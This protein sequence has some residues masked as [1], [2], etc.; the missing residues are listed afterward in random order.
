MDLAYEVA[1]SSG[2]AVLLLH[3]GVADRRMWATQVAAFS[4]HFRTITYDM[5]GF[6]DSPLPTQDFSPLDDIAAL[7]DHLEIDRAHLVG[8]SMGAATA[9][10]FAVDHP[11]RVDKLVLVNSGAPGFTPEEGYYEPPG[12]DDV[13]A[14]FKAGDLDT[15]ADFEV[16]LWVDGPFRS[17]DE[18]SQEVR[19]A[20]RE[21]DLLALRNEDRRDDHIVRPETP[22]GTRL[23]E[24]EATTLVVLSELDV[25]DMKP[26]AEYLAT[27]IAGARLKTIPGVAHMANMESPEFF[28]ELVIGFLRESM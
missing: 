8:C 10:E 5:R 22:A 9:L 20:V 12:W 25:P 17:P 15:V 13:V 18:V 7:L 14:A 27:G 28:N 24:V 16:R 3:A 6:G 4:R 11:E 19:E 21:M 1:G 26:L 2:E 23:D